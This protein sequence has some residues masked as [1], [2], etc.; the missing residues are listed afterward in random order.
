MA[1]VVNGLRVQR[2]RATLGRGAEKYLKP[3]YVPLAL[4]SLPL[5][6]VVVLGVFSLY[7]SFVPLLPTTFD[8]T[9]D[10][11]KGVIR[12]YMITQV[13][14]NTLIVGFG[15]VILALFF[16]API[17]WLLNRTTMPLRTWM[18]MGIAIALIIPGFVKSMGWAVLLNERIGIINKML[19]AIPGV[20]TIPLSVG[21]IWGVAW[22]QG[23]TLTPMVVFLVSG[24]MRQL[25]PALE[26]AAATS[27]VNRF[28][29]FQRISLPL[30]LPAILGAGIYVFMTAV[31]IFEVPAI[32]VGLGG[33]APVLA[34]E[35][36]YAVQ[37]DDVFA[38][39]SFG[40][41]G[42]FAALIMV[43][44]LVALYFYF[45]VINRSYR[46]SVVT[47]KGYRPRL[48]DLGRWTWVGVG[49]VSLYLALN[50]GLPFLALLWS[51]LVPYQLPSL[52]ALDNISF[53]HYHPGTLFTLF[54]GW[55][56]IRNTIVLMVSVGV[57]VTFFSVMIS[58]VVVRT[59]LPIRRPLDMIAMLPHAIPGLAFAFALFVIALVL[60]IRISWLSIRGTL[61]LL[62][63]ANILTQL[64]FTT[65]LT[66]AGLIQ[67]HR[68]LEEAAN[69]CGCATLK[70]IW[71][72]LI[73]LIRPTLGF[74][75]AYV[76]LRTF[77]ELTMAL[78]LASPDSQVVSVKVFQM[79]TDGSPTEAATGGVMLVVVI[80]LLVLLANF[81]SRG[82]ILGRAM[83]T[84]PEGSI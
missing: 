3:H 15:T 13:L 26:E 51:S 19:T 48:V 41:A 53:Q 33:Q 44:S 80:L 5:V 6:A 22:V 69:V 52:S 47:G 66:N 34:T 81:F 18:F 1:S 61:A 11:W 55:S 38:E 2:I 43:P 12:P 77:R 27:G 58:W 28:V 24:P 49:F 83:T 62:I 30:V 67:V 74:A 9:L 50:T 4:G 36:F 60:D 57:G 39:P 46:Y 59:R 72:V 84:R 14:P 21:N 40:S 35:L 20:D 65:R 54:G 31:S 79:W 25:D 70:T 82:R 10:H 16:G 7:M 73:P 56:V 78:F 42:V 75:T 45:K 29:T 32:L 23:L 76:A 37:G 63:I 17:A 71:T 64:S 68:E 8:W